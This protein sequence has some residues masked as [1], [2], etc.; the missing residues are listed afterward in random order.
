VAERL[1]DYDYPLPPAAIAQRPLADRAACRLLVL[2]PASGALADRRF[3]DLPALLAPGDL[4]VINDTRVLPARLRGLRER[5][6]AGEAELL[7]HT[8]GADGRWLGLLRPARRFRPGD[9]F[10][11][12]QGRVQIQVEEPGE[13]GDRWLRLLAPASWAEAMALAGELPLPPYIVRPADARD[14][15]DYQTTFARAEGAVA[16][17]TAGLHFDAPLLAALA[18]RG[19]ACAALTLHVGVGTFLPVR[20]DD[21]AEHRMHAERFTLPAA[22]RRAVDAARAAGGRVIAVGTTVTRTLESPC[23]ADWAGPADLA[24]E[25]RLFIRPPYR[26]RRVDGLVTNFHLPRSTLLMLVA[27]LAGRERVLAAYAHAVLAGY[28]FFSYGDA[29]LLLPGAAAEAGR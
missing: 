16:A 21:P 27:A 22:T 19:V 7:L 24:G 23:E 13:G 9:R 5:A 12:A 8:P 28:R 1:S 11:A 10:L 25:T 17:P 15:E 29:M 3:R 4:L 26:C 2:D 6:G 14:G 18:A 20:V